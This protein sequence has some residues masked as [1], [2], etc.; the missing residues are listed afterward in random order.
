MVLLCAKV[1]RKDISYDIFNRGDYLT[2]NVFDSQF[3]HYRMIK[4]ATKNSFY[5]LFYLLCAIQ[6]P[7]QQRVLHLRSCMRGT[8][9][10]SKVLKSAISR[11]AKVNKFSLVF[12]LN[13]IVPLR[14]NR[15][16]SYTIYLDV[17]RA[18]RLGL[19]LCLTDETKDL[20]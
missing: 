18:S 10:D 14:R 4:M 16:N 1:L 17:N 15:Y 2:T 9:C 20:H 13:E 19:L 3:S 7:F 5:H 11:Q 12:W 8:H 6:L